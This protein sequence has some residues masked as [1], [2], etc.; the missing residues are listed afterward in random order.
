MIKLSNKLIDML[1]IESFFLYNRFD[2]RTIIPIIP[3]LFTEGVKFV[4]NININMLNIEHK[5]THFFAI[6]LFVKMYVTPK[7]NI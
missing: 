4:I 7:Y 2:D 5:K 1:F 3:A 6:L